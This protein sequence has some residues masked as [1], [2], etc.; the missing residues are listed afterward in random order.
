M[1]TDAPR[2][3]LASRR[4]VRVTVSKVAAMGETCGL[5]EIGVGGNER[6]R[7]GVM[8]LGGDEIVVLIPGDCFVL[9]I[10]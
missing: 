9:V 4:R 6:S 2:C 3:D 5:S 8:S 10:V 7:F 1:A